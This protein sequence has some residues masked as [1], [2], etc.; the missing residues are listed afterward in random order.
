M[1]NLNPISARSRDS[2]VDQQGPRPDA[3]LTNRGALYS[4][5]VPP[6]HREMLEAH[7]A[8]MARLFK[9]TPPQ[10]P[11][12]KTEL[13][14][15]ISGNRA[16][17]CEMEKAEPERDWLVTATNTMAAAEFVVTIRSI[18]RVVADFYGVG[19]MDLRSARKTQPVTFYRQ[20]AMYLCKEL[21]TNSLPA[22]GRQFGGRDHTTV[23]HSFRKIDGLRKTDAALDGQIKTL[24]ATIMA[25]PEPV[26]EC[27]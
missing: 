5:N 9:P 22:I 14:I 1:E 12:E 26:T 19:V 2:A 21:T 6:V 11:V 27:E 24:M 23:L 4:P 7:K 15:V 16:A 10:C 8:R 18:Q 3:S 13:Q 17:L 25:K 20:I